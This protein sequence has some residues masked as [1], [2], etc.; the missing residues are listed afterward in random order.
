MFNYIIV[1]K[2]NRIETRHYDL[3]QIW[4]LWLCYCTVSR[5]RVTAIQL[6]LVD[7]ECLAAYNGFPNEKACRQK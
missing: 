7:V 1:V 5:H 4:E 6:Q 3:L 2:F